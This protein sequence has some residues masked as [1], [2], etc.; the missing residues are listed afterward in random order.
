MVVL[1]RRGNVGGVAF[2]I[3]CHLP[4]ACEQIRADVAVFGSGVAALKNG[5]ARERGR[6]AVRG[7][8]GF[9]PGF[10]NNTVRYE[11]AL[12]EVTVLG[13]SI[14]TLKINAVRQGK[15]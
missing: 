7:H 10:L 15:G 12:A 9:I 8:S 14:A 11:Q 4:R 2:C 1:E 3:S 13:S 5:D 6:K